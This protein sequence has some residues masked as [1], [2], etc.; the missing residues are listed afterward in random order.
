MSNDWYN[1]LLGWWMEAM[2]V[3]GLLGSRA[4]LCNTEITLAA[5]TESKPYEARKSA[6]IW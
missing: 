6:R 3:V 5:D 1:R 2:I 4:S